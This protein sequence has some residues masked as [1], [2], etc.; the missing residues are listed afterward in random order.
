MSWPSDPTLPCWTYWQIS[1]LA[2]LLS[3]PGSSNNIFQVRHFFLSLNIDTSWKSYHFHLSSHYFLKRTCWCTWMLQVWWILKSIKVLSIYEYAFV[4]KY[5]VLLGARPEEYWTCD[6]KVA[7]SRILK[8][9]LR[10]HTYL[11]ALWSV[12]VFQ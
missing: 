4:T 2:W 11:F 1:W 5:L 9:Y 6:W 8:G 3:I 12:P 10:L 7:G